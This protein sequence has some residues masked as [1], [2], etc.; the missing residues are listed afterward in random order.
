M[1]NFSTGQIARHLYD[2]LAARGPVRYLD[3]A[4]R[5]V[6]LTADLYVG[7]FWAFADICSMNDFETRIAVYPVADPDRSRRT[8]RALAQE[9]GL[10]S[11]DPYLPPLSF[12]H[13]RTMSLADVVLVTGNSFTLST[14]PDRWHSK[15]RLINYSVDAEVFSRPVDVER[16]ND[17]VFVAT[18]CGMAK[19]FV[20]VLKT[21]S[22]IPK[23]QSTLHVVGRLE[24]PFDDMMQQHNTGS[25]VYE[26]WVD[27][28]TEDYLKILKACRF[29][30][31]P[32]WSEGQ[33]GTL[34]EAVH[35]GCI[36]ITTRNAGLDDRVL[37]HCVIVE[38]RDILGQRAAIADALSW[39][40]AQYEERRHLLLEATAAHQTWA[41]FEM[42]VQ[43]AL[44]GAT[45]KTVAVI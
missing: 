11:P 26:G 14:F 32:T 39:S 30:Y 27:S 7:H 35:A 23:G 13:E 1:A 20:D 10:P 33:M 45:H 31:M 42:T 2:M 34:L 12:D 9:L 19:G 29:A 3:D 37:E 38:P 16:T 15:I 25:T 8:L 41:S 18:H 28:D 24:A 6:G 22:G 17:L 36:P 40:E 43:A 5:P 21:W 44:E 4:D